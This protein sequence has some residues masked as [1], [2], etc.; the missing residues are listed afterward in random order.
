MNAERNKALVKRLVVEAQE[1]G[2]VALL[3]ELMTADF[4]DHRPLPGLPGTRDGVK[5][6]FAGLKTAFPDLAIT[7]EDQIADERS[8]VSRKTFRGTHRGPFLGVAPSGRAVEFEVIDILRACEGRLT[9]HWVVVDQLGLL[10]Q[11][12]APV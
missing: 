6:L 8:V 2:D 4:V 10:R 12:G 5:Q 1:G 9:D 11:L 3:D 7:I